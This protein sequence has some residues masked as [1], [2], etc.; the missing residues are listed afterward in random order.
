MYTGILDGHVDVEWCHTAIIVLGVL[1]VFFVDSGTMSS[2]ENQRASVSLQALLSRPTTSTFSLG[3]FSP[4]LTLVP[5]SM[6][7]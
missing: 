5:V 4:K 2:L 7:S 6:V 3:I 1:F